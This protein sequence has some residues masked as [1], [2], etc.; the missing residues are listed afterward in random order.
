MK[1]GRQGWRF[2]SAPGWPPPPPGWRPRPGWEPDPDW[3]TPPGWRWIRRSWLGPVIAL[4][5]AAFLVGMMALE[6]LA[7]SHGGSLDPTD[8]INFNSFALTNDSG[9]RLYVH[10]CEDAACRKLDGN[11]DWVAVNP[12][13]TDTEQVGWGF[14]QVTYAVSNNGRGEGGYRCLQVDDSKK[15]IST[16]VA[17]LSRATPCR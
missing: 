3:S 4:G 13:G 16:T 7:N 2:V 17:P 5:M 9:G 8:P 11:F 14:G 12:A 1:A 6:A 10:L 15:I